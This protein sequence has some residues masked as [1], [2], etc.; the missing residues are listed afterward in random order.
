MSATFTVIFAEHL[1]PAKV[2]SMS[3]QL[4]PYG[5]VSGGSS[6]RDFSVEVFRRSKIPGL[7][8]Q[9]TKWEVHGFL[10][11]SEQPHP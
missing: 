1:P 9:S 10:R 8:T 2:A 7:Q 5:M 6:G 11:W 4:E 3:G